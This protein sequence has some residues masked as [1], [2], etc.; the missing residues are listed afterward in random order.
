MSNSISS[1][2]GR[3]GTGKIGVEDIS[4]KIDNMYLRRRL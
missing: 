1:S 2:T 4:G 3:D